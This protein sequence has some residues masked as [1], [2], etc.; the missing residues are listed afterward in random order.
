[1]SESIT[2][3]PSQ[4]TSKNKCIRFFEYASVIPLLDLEQLHEDVDRAY[5]QH[6]RPQLCARTYSVPLP[7]SITHLFSS[8]PSRE[9]THD[10]S[11]I[12]NAPPR[13]NLRLPSFTRKRRN[14]ISSYQP[15]LKSCLKRRK[16]LLGANVINEKDSSSASATGKGKNGAT[17]TRAHTLAS[18]APSAS[19]SSCVGNVNPVY[20]PAL[21][22]V[23]S[24]SHNP[25][26][27][28]A[29][30]SSSPGNASSATT[31]STTPPQGDNANSSTQH[32]P[33]TPPELLP[34]RDCCR[35][36]RKAAS[37]G[38]RCSD[39]EYHEHWSK[40][41]LEK[42]KRDEETLFERGEFVSR[43]KERGEHVDE[44]EISEPGRN[45]VEDAKV[46]EKEAKFHHGF[47][48]SPLHSPMH[49]PTHED[50]TGLK[51]NTASPPRSPPHCPAS[52][53]LAHA[54]AQIVAHKEA[55]LEKQA[56][57]AM[58][59]DQARERIA[60]LDVGKL[61]RHEEDEEADGGETEDSDSDAEQLRSPREGDGLQL[62]GIDSAPTSPT[63]PSAT[64][65]KKSK[66]EAE[67]E[68][69]PICMLEGNMLLPCSSRA[70]YTGGPAVS[71]SAQQ[72]GLS[73]E[74]D[75]V[76]NSSSD[77]PD[78][79]VS[80]LS[81]LGL[82]PAS[83]TTNASSWFGN[84]DLLHSP[85]PERS[86]N[87]GKE[88]Q[89]DYFP[90]TQENARYTDEKSAEL[91]PPQKIGE[92]KGCSPLMRSKACLRPMGMYNPAEDLMAQSCPTITEEE[93][94]IPSTP[95]ANAT[96]QTAK[97][98]QRPPTLQRS[99]TALTALEKE[100]ELRAAL[101]EADKPVFTVPS[102]TQSLPAN[103]GSS[104]WH[105]GDHESADEGRRTKPS[106]TTRFL[107]RG[108][109]LS[110]LGVAH[111]VVH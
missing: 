98:N 94:S 79:I 6:G 50:E 76:S 59:V 89:Q 107:H 39:A 88:G 60:R 23:V 42:R 43:K 92:G 108:K 36:C 33:P 61:K 69:N 10:P 51:H 83:A 84:E 104:R 87:E 31:L 103:A 1:M 7:T 74:M 82:S 30:L 48:H 14:T 8:P 12:P 17:R 28:G 44:G 18:S 110:S 111:G 37:Y 5:G 35:A 71:K 53:L 45:V 97:P 55:R 63:S 4:D 41:A 9:Y 75:R 90:S 72:G 91:T 13:L 73:A 19:A 49:S 11:F 102:R 47:H 56:A 20:C 70:L 68:K 54:H 40:A 3:T 21:A 86:L 26:P 81:S 62:E 80:S 95:D 106:W 32:L 100:A 15:H 99:Q 105:A 109:G 27:S 34:I 85:L 66:A 96:A 101:V 57:H 24:E 2:A 22:K 67:V 52:P 25:P 46:L 29:N 16:P 93:G 77:L 64:I 65:G 78:D 38:E 58:E